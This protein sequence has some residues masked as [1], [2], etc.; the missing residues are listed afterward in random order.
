MNNTIYAIVNLS[1]TNA[2]LFSQV[3]E[4]S[5]QT[6]IRNNANTQ[7][8]ISYL[9]EPSFITNGALTPVSILNQT[10]VLAL[11]QTPEW[12]VPLPNE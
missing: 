9:V 3:A 10:E 6:M 5:T 12:K 11:M 4:D 7:G 8:I 2:I 1:D